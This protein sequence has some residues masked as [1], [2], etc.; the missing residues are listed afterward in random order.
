M[1]TPFN[2]LRGCRSGAELMAVI[3]LLH[4][5]PDLFQNQA[6]NQAQ[7][8]DKIGPPFSLTGTPCQR[9]HFYPHDDSLA[10]RYCKVCQMILAWTFR[11]NRIANAAIVI[12]GFVNYIPPEI[13]PDKLFDRTDFHGVYIHDDHHFLMMLHRKK[14]AEWIRE[15]L[16]YQG[17]DIKGLIQIFPTT[18]NSKRGNMGDILCRAVHHEAR[19]PMDLLRV[20]FY[21]AA[22]QIFNPQ[23]REKRGVL[24]FEV[25]E[26]LN[27]LEMATVFRTLLNS[28]ARK[29]FL[30]LTQL[31]SVKEEQFYWGRFMGFLSDEAKDMLNSWNIRQWPRTRIQLLYELLS[32]VHYSY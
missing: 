1:L 11:Q 4:K 29:N 18:G 21:S 2:W 32:Y 27:L 19:F 10:A 20:R 12:W 17:S 25:S 13:N 16:I 30:E 3:R 28:D 5:S 26:F 6:Q 22:H 9:C 31:K 14:I 24:T 8:Q 23:S 7:N 15:L